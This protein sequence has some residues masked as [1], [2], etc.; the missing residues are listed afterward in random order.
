MYTAFFLKVSAVIS[1]KERS[2]AFIAAG[3]WGALK[4]LFGQDLI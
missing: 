1:Q 2:F 4:G 3:I